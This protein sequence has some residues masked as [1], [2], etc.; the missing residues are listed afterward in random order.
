MLF[1]LLAPSIS[2]C[3]IQNAGV[4]ADLRAV[5]ALCIDE[6]ETLEMP[7]LAFPGWEKRARE[8]AAQAT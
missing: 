3:S 6:F 5:A 7:L 4:G 1:T 2:A 8:E